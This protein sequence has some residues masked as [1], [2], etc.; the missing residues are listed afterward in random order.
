MAGPLEYTS[1]MNTN[2]TNTMTATLT[3]PATAPL[4]TWFTELS[5]DTQADITEMVNENGYP[6]TDIQDF[7]ETYGEQAYVAGYYVTWCE[8]TEQCGADNEAIEAY[9]DEVGIDAISSF[10][11]AYMG[12]YDGEAEF[13]EQ[14]YVDMLGNEIP[15]AIV[16]D[17]QATWDS[18]LRYDYV[19]N[20]GYVFN[21][22]V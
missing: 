18:N 16:V 7:V 3:A 11:D 2:E 6:L 13:A 10:E 12:E 1:H 20:N 8:L 21:S 17:W 4:G 9:V 15:D 22:N 19:Y 5:A 14:Y